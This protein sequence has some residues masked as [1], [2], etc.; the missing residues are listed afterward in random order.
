MEKRNELNK[1]DVSKRKIQFADKLSEKIY[2]NLLNTQET[3]NISYLLEAIRL[4]G[5]TPD[6]AYEW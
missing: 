5:I 4:S 6:P 2:Y 3:K 1:V